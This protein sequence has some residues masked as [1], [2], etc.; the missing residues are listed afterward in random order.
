M[1]IVI[2]TNTLNRC[3]PVNVLYNMVEAYS[4]NRGNHEFVMLTLSDSLDNSRED[5]FKRIGVRTRS[6]HINNKLLTP[7]KLSIIRK[8]ITEENPDVVHASGFRAEMVISYIKLPNIKKVASIF[9]YVFEDLEMLYG[10]FVGGIMANLVVNNYKKHFD[11]TLP[12]SEYIINKYIQRYNTVPFNYKII[13]TGVSDVFFKPLTAE[14]RVKQRAK[15][16]ISS[17]VI[18]YLF[19]A[20]FIPR[21]N[22]ELIVKAFKDFGSDNILLLMMGDG[23]LRNKCELMWNDNRH[24]RY[25]GSQPSTLEYLQI[26]DYIVSASYSEGFPTAVLEAM[27]VGVIPVLSNIG[28][29][30]EMLAGVDSP[31]MFTPDNEAELLDLLAMDKSNF[32]YR[33]YFMKNFSSK[34]MYKKHIEAYSSLIS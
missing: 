29:H 13:Y 21:K 26:S 19:C 14:Q 5:D 18:V 16:N 2:V 1:K 27:S 8:T 3:G 23:P 10:K 9:N 32:N 4:Q 7:F 17:D 34:V 31:R 11:L 33:D 12:C 24:I 6:L 22:P 28:P 25:L 20:V 15:Y 30:K